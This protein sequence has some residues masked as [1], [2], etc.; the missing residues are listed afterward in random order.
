M[1]STNYRAGKSL[2]QVQ[3][4]LE[5]AGL[6]LTEA[7]EMSAAYRKRHPQITKVWFDEVSPPTVTF[8]LTRPDPSIR[9]TAEL[10]PSK[11][12]TYGPQRKGKGGKVKRW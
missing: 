2:F 4:R 12:I 8:S 7:L 10:K 5:L 9:E 11:K 3:G 6:D 1:S